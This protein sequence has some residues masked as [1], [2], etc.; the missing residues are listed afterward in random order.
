MGELGKVDSGIIRDIFNH[1][2]EIFLFEKANINEG[3]MAE[4]S[5]RTGLLRT[6]IVF[7]H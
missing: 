4:I 5:H 3:L 6:N 2:L 1:E 7:V